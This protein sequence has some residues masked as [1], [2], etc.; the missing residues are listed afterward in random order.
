MIAK[1]ILELRFVG[2]TM[3]VAVRLFENVCTLS[4]ECDVV[5]HLIVEHWIF[6]FANVHAAVLLFGIVYNETA[7]TIGLIELLIFVIVF[8]EIA[9]FRPWNIWSR[10]ATNTAF[11]HQF[12]YIQI[13]CVCADDK[14]VKSVMWPDQL[15]IYIHSTDRKMHAKW[16]WYIQW[17]IVNDHQCHH[18]FR[19]FRKILLSL[20]I[21][22]VHI[23]S[24]QVFIVNIYL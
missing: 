22:F 14:W 19:C 11:Q 4:L 3:E 1:C 17:A 23:K 16:K 13:I 24:E 15:D 8:D 5:R 20:V 9:V 2:I 7:N 18:T 10:F 12:V 21:L 6:R